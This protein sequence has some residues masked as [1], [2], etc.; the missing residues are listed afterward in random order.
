MSKTSKITAPV[1]YKQC[2]ITPVPGGTGFDVFEQ[3]G[4]WFHVAT[5][6]QA[7]W[8]SSIHDR[9]ETEFSRHAIRPLP[10]VQA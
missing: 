2:V 6:K 4:R 10:E 8:W 9:L 1:K 7:K 5:Q 3:N